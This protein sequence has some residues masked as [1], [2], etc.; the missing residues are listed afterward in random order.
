MISFRSVP[1]Q[2]NEQTYIT[3]S[4]QKHMLMINHTH[5]FE[6]SP[7]YLHN[8]VD[9][10]GDIQIMESLDKVSL[11][12][13]RTP[14]PE[15]ALAAKKLTAYFINKGFVTVSGLAMGIDTIV[16]S[17]T[18]A[19]NGKTVA[20]LGTPINKVYPKENADLFGRIEKSGLIISQ[21]PLGSRTQ[22]SHFPQR[23]KTMAFLSDITI[24]CDAT[25]KS[26]TKHQVREALRLNKK[27][28]ILSHIL[29]SNKTPW[30]VSSLKQGALKLEHDNLHTLQ[31]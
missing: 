6:D 26:G 17:E 28:Y 11:I 7:S 2:R 1:M 31:V 13:S 3:P 21:F 24:V 23:N 16:H 22:R 12:G 20:V 18:L 5:H 25:Q 27:V 30:A 15:G 10:K 14:T 9:F 4:N 8:G 19:L 29:E